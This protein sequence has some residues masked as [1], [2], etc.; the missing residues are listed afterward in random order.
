[1]HEMARGVSPALVSYAKNQDL[2]GWRHFMEGMGALGCLEIQ[3]G[4]M[5]ML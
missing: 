4:Y 3:S 2:I 5:C 1:M